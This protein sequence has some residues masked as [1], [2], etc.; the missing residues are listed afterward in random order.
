MVLE[1]KLEIEPKSLP[2]P[3]ALLR[4]PVLEL[5]RM[6]KQA[7]ELQLNLSKRGQLGMQST[8]VGSES[9]AATSTFASGFHACARTWTQSR[10]TPRFAIEFA[11]GT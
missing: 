6:L 5:P 4:A 10:S 9:T 7:F 3:Q 2:L 1:L 11:A 8:I